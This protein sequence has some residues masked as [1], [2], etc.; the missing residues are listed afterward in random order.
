MAGNKAGSWKSVLAKNGI[1]SEPI[2]TGLA[3]NPDIVTVWL[4]HLDEALS[5]L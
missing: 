2:F 5:K 4:D 3:E 1:E